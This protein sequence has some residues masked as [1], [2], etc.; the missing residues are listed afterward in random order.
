VKW[1]RDRVETGLLVQSDL[2]A[3][4]VQLATFQQR[5]VAAEGEVIIA[6][7]T[8]ATA[9]G[10]PHDSFEPVGALT[11]ASFPLPAIDDLLQAAT[12]SRHDLHVARLDTKIAQAERRTAT[13]ALLPRVDAFANFGASGA[14]ISEHDSDHVVGVVTSWRLLDAAAWTRRRRAIE[15]I[16]LAN[17]RETETTNQ[18][19]L[20]VVT[21]YEHTRAAAA[22][23]AI[24]SHAIAQ[25][26]EVR[27]IVHDRYEQG[28]TSI[29]ELLRAEDALLDARVLAADARFEQSIAY[30]ELLQSSGQ[31]DSLDAFHASTELVPDQTRGE[32][33]Q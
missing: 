29:T 18:A 32:T 23:D 1:I 10:R 20:A 27:R 33:R 15:Q 13:G 22:R 31:L 28:L 30:A 9:L 24:A 2:L 19:E 12:S 4:E 7:R 17:A 14:S 26:E 16:A 11:S 21:A 5:A 8:L 6:R 3:A 25:A